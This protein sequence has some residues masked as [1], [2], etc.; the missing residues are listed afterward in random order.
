MKKYRIYIRFNKI[1][2]QYRA[3]LEEEIQVIP[4]IFEPEKELQKTPLPFVELL[5]VKDQFISWL[6]S[7]TP[8]ITSMI[9]YERW[10]NQQP[11]VTINRQKFVI[12]NIGEND[13]MMPT[14]HNFD[15]YSNKNPDFLELKNCI[16]PIVDNM[17]DQDLVNK[18]MDNLSETVFK[19]KLITPKSLNEYFKNPYTYRKIIYRGAQSKGIEIDGVVYPW[20]SETELL[21]FDGKQDIE[22]QQYFQNV[23]NWIYEWIKTKYNI[24]VSEDI[25]NLYDQ[26]ED[27][28]V[29]AVDSIIKLMID[30]EIPTTTVDYDYFINTY[31]KKVKTPGLRALPVIEHNGQK[32]KVSVWSYLNNSN[33]KSRILTKFTAGY[34]NQV[35]AGPYLAQ[36]IDYLKEKYPNY[37]FLTE[38]SFKNFGNF[39]EWLE[40]NFVVK[41][42]RGQSYINTFSVLKF[43]K[44]QGINEFNLSSLEEKQDKFTV[45][46][47]ENNPTSTVDITIKRPTKLGPTNITSNLTQCFIN[48][49]KYRIDL[50]VIKP[51]G[52]ITAFEAD[53][54]YHYGVSGHNINFLADFVNDQLQKYFLEEFMGIRLIRIP[55]YIF[56]SRRFEKLLEIIEDKI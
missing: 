36:N 43:F 39:N 5:K 55:Y 48:P 27:T 26:D 42:Y 10:F 12:A 17:L 6:R 13:Y 40:T 15:V 41:K 3:E 11:S 1:T 35:G 8:P 24:E 20:P 2:K 7:Q 46:F 47:D 14:R 31:L 29:G 23:L 19:D 50:V 9:A 54:E 45:D 28:I 56:G 4:G 33:A 37:K 38:Y 25:P 44:D 34:R 51:N 18:F 32:Y 49:N 30:R 52:E 53:G 22:R 21:V 16:V